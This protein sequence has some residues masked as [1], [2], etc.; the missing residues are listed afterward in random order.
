MKNLFFLMLL[1]GCGFFH[2]KASLERAKKEAAE[3]KPQNANKVEKLKVDSST[4]SL[5]N[6]GEAKLYSF[7]GKDFVKVAEAFVRS[8]EQEAFVISEQDL[9]SGKIE[10]VLVDKG[11]LASFNDSFAGN[12]NYKVSE[13]TLI[14]VSLSKTKEG[15]Q[16]EMLIKKFSVYSMGQEEPEAFN[17]LNLYKDIIARVNL[18]L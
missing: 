7:A 9:Q 3:K 4:V 6:K 8:L 12:S 2:T 13:N 15:V 16:S 11:S 1:C 10:A 5:E 17:N 18:A 14:Q